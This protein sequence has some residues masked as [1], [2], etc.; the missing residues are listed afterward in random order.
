[1]SVLQSLLDDLPAIQAWR[2]QI[3]AYPELSFEEHATAALVSRLLESWGIEV[4]EGIA[5]TGVVGRLKH[6]TST[7]AIGLRADM[8]ALPLQEANTFAHASKAAGKMHACGHDGH[9]AMLLAAARHLAHTRQFDGCVN[10]VFQPAEERGGGG[11]KMIE[12]GLFER[13]A[14]DAIFGLHNWPGLP[15]GHFSVMPGPMMAGTNGFGVTVKGRSAHAAMP[16]LGAEALTAACRLVQELH[17]LLPREKD[18]L[19][20]AVVTVTQIHSGDSMNV[21]PETAVI[22]GTVRAFDTHVIDRIESSLRRIAQ[23]VGATYD[24]QCEVAFQRNYPPLVN[25][26]A[27]TAFAVEAMR[28]VVGAERVQVGTLRTLAAEDFAYMLQQRAGCYAFLG[29]GDGAHRGPDYNVGPCEL[30]NPSYDFN[31][32]LLP[33]GASYFVALAER[34]L[35]NPFSV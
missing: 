19:D 25:H 30:H 7:R 26:A 20:A 8:D 23:H 3:H 13:F 29:N 22:R 35:R 14:C 2:H 6:G 33:V 1:M 4:T 24:V 27:E 32:A 31:D 16:H 11:R 18:P 5:G 28:A 10:F 15:E 34:W 17:L 12:E 9:V 21:I